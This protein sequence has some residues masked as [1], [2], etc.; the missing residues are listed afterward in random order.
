MFFLETQPGRS[1]AARERSSRRINRLLRPFDMRDDNWLAS[2]PH[3][4]TH[5]RC[6]V[7]L[8]EIDTDISV[9]SDVVIAYHTL[10]F[11][12]CI[13]VELYTGG[14]E[15]WQFP[16]QQKLTVAS[17]GAETWSSPDRFIRTD[18]RGAITTLEM[19]REDGVLRRY[20]PEKPFIDVFGNYVSGEKLISNYTFLALL[21]SFW[22]QIPEKSLE[23]LPDNIDKRRDEVW[24]MSSLSE[25]KGK[26][27]STAE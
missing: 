27:Q 8:T 20:Q 25:G 14:S 15:Q 23:K 24:S 9:N 18:G 10:H 21:P 17:N 12:S 4:W 16:S 7:T 13:T 26:F 6:P 19:A 5:K 2:G 11:W 3:R 22:S 1:K